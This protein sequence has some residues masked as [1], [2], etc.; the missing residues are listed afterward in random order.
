MLQWDFNLKDD[1][2]KKKKKFHFK[3]I[4]FKVVCHYNIRER[5]RMENVE[6]SKTYNVNETK[7]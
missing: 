7:K 3:I 6:C 5:V 1:N 2:V 4:L